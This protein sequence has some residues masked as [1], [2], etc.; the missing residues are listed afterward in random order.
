[1]EKMLTGRVLGG[2]LVCRIFAQSW[3]KK[4]YF[5]F[6]QTSTNE[7]SSF[8][9]LNLINKLMTSHNARTINVN[10]VSCVVKREGALTEIL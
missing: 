8:Y 6:G 1:M 5:R 2:R 9:V 4:L 10:E 3:S 7:S